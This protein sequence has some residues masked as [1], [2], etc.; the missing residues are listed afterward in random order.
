MQRA[1]IYPAVCGGRINLLNLA[2]IEC[3]DFSVDE[4]LIFFCPAD[5]CNGEHHSFG[6]RVSGQEHAIPFLNTTY[7]GLHGFRH[8]YRDRLVIKDSGE[9]GGFHFASEVIDALRVFVGYHHV[10]KESQ[11]GIQIT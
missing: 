10:L 11:D 2:V 7:A 6:I 8:F 9:I 4:N 5:I 3:L 1:D